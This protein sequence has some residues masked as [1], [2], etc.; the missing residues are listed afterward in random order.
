MAGRRRLLTRL[1]GRRALGLRYNLEVI[2]RGP[3]VYKAACR[4]GLEGIVSARVDAPYVS[5]KVKTLLKVKNPDARGTTRF[6][7][8]Q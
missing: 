8:P 6:I 4:M 1:L 3:E 7:D 2:G 5:G